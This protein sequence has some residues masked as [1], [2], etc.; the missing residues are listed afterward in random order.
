MVLAKPDYLSHVQA[1]GIMEVFITAYQ[2][3]EVLGKLGPK[4]SV[5]IH[6][7]A[8]SVGIAANQVRTRSCHLV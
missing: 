3:L 2:A 4:E 1:A 5:L 7:G 6:A 8:S